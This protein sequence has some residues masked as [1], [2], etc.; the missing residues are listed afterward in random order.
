MTDQQNPSPESVNIDENHIMAERREKLAAL[1]TQG[2]AF[3]ND[4]IP[5]HLAIDLHDAYSSLSKEELAEKNIS[6]KMAGRM[7]LKRVMGKASF[8]RNW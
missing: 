8:A 3:P 2:I 7:M 6:V 4:F 5:T 1:R